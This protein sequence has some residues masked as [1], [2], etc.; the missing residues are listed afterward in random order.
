VGV[1][2]PG[3]ATIIGGGSIQTSNIGIQEIKSKISK[4]KKTRRHGFHERNLYWKRANADTDSSLVTS[5][6]VI[7]FPQLDVSKICS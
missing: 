4:A 7:E 3:L 6:I 2:D 5:S 1:G